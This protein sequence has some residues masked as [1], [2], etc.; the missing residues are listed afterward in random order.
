MNEFLYCD[1]LLKT[2]QI[3]CLCFLQYP[4]TQS[5]STSVNRFSHEEREKFYAMYKKESSTIV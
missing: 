1:R 2:L 5:G 4:N 3:D